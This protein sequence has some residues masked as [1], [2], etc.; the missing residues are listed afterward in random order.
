[1]NIIIAFMGDN[2]IGKST[3]ATY[4]LEK[5][6]VPKYSL[7]YPIKEA[8]RTLFNLSDNQLYNDD[9]DKYD[10]NLGFVPRN[11]MIKFATYCKAN[12]GDDI[13]CK[14]LISK[15]DKSYYIST[16]DDM[17]FGNEIEFFKHL[18]DDYVLYLVYIT[19]DETFYNNKYD[20]IIHNTGTLSH[21]YNCLDSVYYDIVGKWNNQ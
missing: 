16:I 9:K 3:C 1:M 15:I 4:L 5:H 17:R 14:S 10:D 13:F 6:N 21:L 18:S 20:Y 8:M 19:H 11:E 12:Y 2:R 7:A